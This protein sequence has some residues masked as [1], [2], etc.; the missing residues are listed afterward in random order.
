MDVAFRAPSFR[1]D[2]T[3]NDDFDND[4]E[5]STPTKDASSRTPS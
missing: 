4:N 2:I 1:G 5:D 3:T